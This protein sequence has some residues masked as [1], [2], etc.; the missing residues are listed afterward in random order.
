MFHMTR[1][2]LVLVSAL[3]AASLSAT[4][5]VDFAK[6]SLPAGLVSKD[7][8]PSAAAVVCFLEGPAV[9]ADGNVFFSD[10]AGNRIPQ[11]G[12]QRRRDRLPRR[13]RPHERQLLR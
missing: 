8:T 13:Q 2:L 9:D 11:D 10:I 6:T 3:A 1:L 7:V 5:D 12:C 4:A